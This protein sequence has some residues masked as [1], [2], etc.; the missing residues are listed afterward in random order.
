MPAPT[1]LPVLTGLTC[2]CDMT[3]GGGGSHHDMGSVTQGKGSLD[4]QGIPF[5][6]VMH[7]PAFCPWCWPQWTTA[8]CKQTT[9]AVPQGHG[10]C[11]VLDL[12][13]GWGIKPQGHQGRPVYVPNCIQL[14]AARRFDMSER[15]TQGASGT[16]TSFN[17]PIPS[18]LGARL[19][20]VSFGIW[21]PPMCLHSKWGRPYALSISR[22]KHG[23]SAII[24]WGGGGQSTGLG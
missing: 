11:C 2:S 14:Q 21:F 6:G 12:G 16:L 22:T 1:P 7:C 23:L 9:E 17:K 3:R 20:H 5:S 18:P 4:Q 13:Q 24:Q 15:Q 19:W 10:S 8:I